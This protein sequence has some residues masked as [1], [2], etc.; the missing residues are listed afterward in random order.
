MGDK[1]IPTRE[2]KALEGRLKVLHWPRRNEDRRRVLNFLA[3]EQ[4]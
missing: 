4:S 2:W 3:R 1:G